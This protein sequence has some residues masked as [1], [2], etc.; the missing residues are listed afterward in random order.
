MPDNGE[1]PTPTPTP[2]PPN[3]AMGTGPGGNTKRDC[4]NMALILAT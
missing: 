3:E 2:T 1:D 4:T